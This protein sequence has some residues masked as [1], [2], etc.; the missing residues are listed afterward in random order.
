MQSGTDVVQ[1]ASGLG[2]KVERQGPQMPMSMPVARPAPTPSSAP[3][4]TAFPSTP[5][6]GG[7]RRRSS[8]LQS[9]S[10]STSPVKYKA[11]SGA[12]GADHALDDAIRSLKRLSVAT[13]T[14]GFSPSKQSRWSISSDDTAT[15]TG[16][17]T[18]ASDSQ[19]LPRPSFDS[20]RS[21]ISLARSR[22]SEDK[23]KTRPSVEELMMM[24][25]AFPE[26]PPLPVPTTPKRLRGLRKLL[27]P[28]KKQSQVW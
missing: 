23:D 22:K 20:V 14:T 8:V 19:S 9:N 27:T 21:K 28:K 3:P 15:G 25:I 16:T 7:R 17:G 6:G 26:V 1:F 5:G 4:P 12:A 24:D 2:Y 13:A 18:D 11:R 10:N